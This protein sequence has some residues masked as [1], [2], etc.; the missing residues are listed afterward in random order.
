[1]YF[2]DRQNKTVTHYAASLEPLSTAMVK[3]RKQQVCVLRNNIL[4]LYVQ[5]IQETYHFKLTY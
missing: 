2:I 1:M 3:T 5:L 4:Y